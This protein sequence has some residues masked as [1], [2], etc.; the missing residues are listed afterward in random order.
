[1]T[2]HRRRLRPE[3]RWFEIETQVVRAFG[4]G[5]QINFEVVREPVYLHSLLLVLRVSCCPVVVDA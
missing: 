1:M 2:L 4:H 3:A 5:D